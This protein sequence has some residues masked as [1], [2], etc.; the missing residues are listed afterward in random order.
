M[1]E[2]L[3]NPEG[4]KRTWKRLIY[5]C[6]LD[7]PRNFS[8]QITLDPEERALLERFVDQAK[9]LAQASLMSASDSVTI[10]IMDLTDEESIKSVFSETDVTVGFMVL[11]RQCYAADEEASFSKAAKILGRRVNEQKDADAQAVAASWHKAHSRLGNKTLEELVQHYLIGEGRMAAE[12]RGPDGK[13][14]SMVVRSPAPPKELFAKLWYGDQ[15]HWG[16]H[17]ADLAQIRADPFDDA[18]WEITTRQAAV[19]LAH[20]YLGYALLIKAA[21]DA[22]AT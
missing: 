14:H 4:A 11:L 21:L 12:S 17:R 19:E 5:T 1:G 3:K 6:R 18:M 9:T 7:D 22:A 10:N 8:A 16:K 2:L 13:V 20:F 15:V